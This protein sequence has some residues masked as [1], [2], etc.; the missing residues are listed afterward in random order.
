M[1][2]YLFEVHVYG[3][4]VVLCESEKEAK[5]KKYLHTFGCL[6]PKIAKVIYPKE[7]YLEL[8]STGLTHI[9]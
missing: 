1:D 5:H 9:Y 8:I 2:I 4:N 3:G 7:L 6:I